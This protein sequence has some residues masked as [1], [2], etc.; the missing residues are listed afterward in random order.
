MDARG[1][2]LGCGS[3]LRGGGLLARVGLRV[4]VWAVCAVPVACSVVL[5]SAMCRLL[6]VRVATGESSVGGVGVGRT[7]R[8]AAVGPHCSSLERPLAGEP[9]GSLPVAETSDQR[10]S[11]QSSAAPTKRELGRGERVLPGVFRLRLPL[12]WPGVPHGNAWAV[13]AGRRGGA[14]RHGHARAGLASRTWNG[15]WRCAACASRT[16][17][18]WC[19]RTRTPTTTAR[20]PRSWNARAASCGCTP[21]T[22]T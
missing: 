3:L 4:A 14:V 6:L 15:R 16:C 11:E 13:A 8:G 20:R 9:I 10:A 1:G 22:S 2:L 18:W 12:P 7:A 17:G 5:S 19:A 21:T